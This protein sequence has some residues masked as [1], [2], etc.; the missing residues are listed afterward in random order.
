MRGPAEEQN[1]V[2]R[3]ARFC[4]PPPGMAVKEWCPL[5]HRLLHPLPSGFI[6]A[7]GDTTFITTPFS[8]MATYVSLMVGPT[9]LGFAATTPAKV[10]T[11]A[12]PSLPVEANSPGPKQGGQKAQ[13]GAR[14]TTETSLWSRTGFPLP[15][16][17]FALCYNGA[18]VRQK[19]KRLK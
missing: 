16:F 19:K 5:Q 12:P 8:G 18:K 3:G 11:P 1:G 2:T 14:H 6:Y 4:S 7:T 15:A 13:Q 10:V 17:F 9:P